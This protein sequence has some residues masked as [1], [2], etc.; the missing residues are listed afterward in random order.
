MRYSCL[1]WPDDAYLTEPGAAF[2]W[3]TSAFTE[4]GPPGPT[5][6]TLG[7]VV[8][9]LIGAKSVAT[10]NGRSFC[11]LA[12]MTIGVVATSRV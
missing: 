10:L 8:I 3:A 2:A 5:T 11:R 6:S 12:L 7:T 4:G 1:P 9:R